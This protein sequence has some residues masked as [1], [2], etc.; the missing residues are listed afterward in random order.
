MS[1]EF[2][3]LLDLEAETPDAL[4]QSISE[5]LEEAVDSHR[6]IISSSI[7]SVP[8]TALEYDID[9]DGEG[10]TL[11]VLYQN[12]SGQIKVDDYRIREKK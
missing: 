1:K 10:K 12:S 8:Y 4:E 3:A 2:E 7:E 6:K 11:S 9:L 5:I